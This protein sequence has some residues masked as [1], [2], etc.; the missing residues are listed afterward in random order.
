MVM[1]TWAAGKGCNVWLKEK[2]TKTKT[3][4][5]NAQHRKLMW[6]IPCGKK[7]DEEGTGTHTLT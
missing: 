5:L 6:S 3:G 1:K 2:A 4:V 7:V